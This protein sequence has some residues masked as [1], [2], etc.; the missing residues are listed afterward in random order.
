V[1]INETS[2][3]N[4]DGMSSYLEEHTLP[5]ETVVLHLIRNNQPLDVALVLGKRPPPPA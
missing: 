5:H 4:R 3:I 1:G 2:V